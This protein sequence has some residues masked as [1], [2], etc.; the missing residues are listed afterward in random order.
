M[1]KY[2]AHIAIGLLAF[3]LASCG[4]NPLEEKKNELAS[5]KKEA[6]A[7]QEKIRGLESEISKLDTAKRQVKPKYVKL[8]EIKASDFSHFIDLQGIL[9]SEDNVMV[10]PK[11][12]G[13]ITAVNVSEGQTV[14]AGQ[15]LA[16]IDNAVILNSIMEIENQLS[17]AKTVYEKQKRLW[18]QNIGT[19]IQ[20][21]QAKNNKEALEKRL[22]TAQTQLSMSKI[23]APFAGIVDEVNIKAGETAAPGFGGIRVLNM[24][25]LKIVAKVADAYVS[26]MKKGDKVRVFLPDLNTSFESVISYAGLNVAAASRTFEIEIKIPS[27]I[28][29]LRPNLLARISVNDGNIPSAIV[30]PVNTVQKSADGSYSVMVA[31]SVN[32]KKIARSK[33]VVLGPSYNNQIVINEG[34]S[35]KEM[36]ITEGNEDLID[37]QELSE[38]K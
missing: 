1:N 18:D 29:N 5:L 32:G 22:A 28:K 31:E 35:L 9:E 12:G 14:S 3:V 7:I 30:I 26:S 21:L 6:I 37:G 33:K 24:N 23:V 16:T 10:N 38:A 36:L 11:M 27:G 13:L 17:L 8:T 2:S 19:E 25:K 34:L 15:V 4:K 20:Y